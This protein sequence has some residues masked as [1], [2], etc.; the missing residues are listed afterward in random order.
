VRTPVDNRDDVQALH[1]CSNPATHSADPA[2]CCRR[3][4]P[5]GLRLTILGLLRPG[6]A[7]CRA[8]RAG[9]WQLFYRH[10]CCSGGDRGYYNASAAT[11]CRDRGSVGPMQCPQLHA[12]H[13][14]LGRQLQAGK[15][16]SK[17][18]VFIY[19]CSV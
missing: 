3:R 8:S 10:R 19:F 6:T 13:L 16:L 4:L 11:I 15:M 7:V 2:S 17:Y 5:G 12:L 18:G 1:C 14:V 9:W